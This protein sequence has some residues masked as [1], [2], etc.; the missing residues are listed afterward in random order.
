M[1]GE[2]RWTKTDRTRVNVE[3]GQDKQLQRCDA[4]GR[5]AWAEGAKFWSE[6]VQRAFMETMHEEEQPRPA[7][8]GSCRDRGGL[9]ATL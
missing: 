8:L 6:E 3:V 7:Y 1:H 5:L 4:A 2:V 9:G